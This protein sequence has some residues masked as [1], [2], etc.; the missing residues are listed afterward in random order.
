VISGGKKKHKVLD[1]A[2]RPWEDRNAFSFKKK[3]VGKVKEL[4]NYLFYFFLSRQW[5][6]HHVLTRSLDE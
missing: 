1:E 3:N 6:T 4:F 5:K 2:Y